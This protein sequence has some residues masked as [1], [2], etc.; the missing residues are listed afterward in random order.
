M[1]KDVSN[2]DLV[3]SISS[4]PE[5]EL[6]NRGTH[7]TDAVHVFWN[8]IN[9]RKTS[10]FVISIA[11]FVMAIS[12]MKEGARGL[13]PLIRV[14]LSVDHPI[15]CLGFGWF[16][17]YFVMSGSPVAASA[18][19]LFDAG[20]IDKL[21]ALTMITGS[22]LGASFVVLFIGFLYALR[23]RDK[24]NSISTGLLTL[25]ITATI[26]LL[27]LSIGAV[28]LSTGS[29]DLIQLQ[30]SKL[31]ISLTDT[32]FEPVTLFCAEFLPRWGLFLISLGI[33]M[34][35]FH[36]FDKCLPQ[37]ELKERHWE[38]M[39]KL[40]YQP[41]VMFLIGAALTIVS[42]SVSVSIGFLV[43]LNSK[44]FIRKENVI[45][46]IMG[47]N[48]TTFIDTLLAAILL[49]NPS[50]F[51][52]VFI[53][54]ISIAVVSFFVLATIYKH[55]ERAMLS[56]AA[57]ATVNNRNLVAFIVLLVITPIVLMVL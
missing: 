6:Q 11:L 2:I 33:I 52:I 30:P 20:A 40:T 16:F 36:L 45:P 50:A 25:S 24:A 54:I 57:W 35:S 39:S 37:T 34:V 26:Y 18:L 12:L 46:Y 13:V 31:I 42:M 8:R 15:N 17:A 49:K 27:G 22:R 1:E 43:P 41:W 3:V 23:G 7:F 29:L 38:R 56:F 51:T 14:T 32:L 55:Y 44:G 21:G 10:L 4:L 19:T 28:L 5:V 47:A 48:V 53:E 9:F